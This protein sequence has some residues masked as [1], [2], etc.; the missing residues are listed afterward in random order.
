MSVIK[1]SH[2]R[3]RRKTSLE[4]ISRRVRVR[5]SEKCTKMFDAR[6]LLSCLLRRCSHVSVFI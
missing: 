2:V 4:R 6:A 5:T 3:Q 1:K